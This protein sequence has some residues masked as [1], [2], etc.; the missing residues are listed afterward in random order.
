MATQEEL[1]GLRAELL[2]TLAPPTAV[3]EAILTAGVDI[4]EE[5]DTITLGVGGVLTE[6]DAAIAE[7]ASVELVWTPDTP[8]STVKD[9]F[10]AAGHVVSEDSPIV[11][12][13]QSGGS[14]PE[15]DFSAQVSS[16]FNSNN[17]E[18]LK[19]CQSVTFE[20]DGQTHAISGGFYG[21]LDGLG[22]LTL[23]GLTVNRRSD[24]PAAV[25]VESVVADVPVT[26]D[27]CVFTAD[28]GSNYK[29]G[30]HIKR[31][32]VLAADCDFDGFIEHGI[33]AHSPLGV[34]VAECGFSDCGRTG[35]QVSRRG[36]NTH[37]TGNSTPIYVFQCTFDNI[38]PEGYAISIWGAS[39]NGHVSILNN[40]IV[41]C[42]AGGVLISDEPGWNSVSPQD[43]LQWALGQGYDVSLDGSTSLLSG[44]DAGT[45][46]SE[47]KQP[48]PGAPWE[49]MP[50][51]HTRWDNFPTSTAS[52]IGNTVVLD[53][54]STRKEY[55]LEGARAVVT[56]QHAS[57]E[58]FSSQW[59]SDH[60]FLTDAPT[61]QA[62][63]TE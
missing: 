6:L 51:V 39:P 1:S 21:E 58:Y 7:L 42:L 36:Y 56:D 33:Y 29:W 37:V 13:M 22:S 18:W 54:A 30:A 41:D 11:V 25:M 50:P 48:N 45:A 15:V 26:L 10:V 5:I 40:T 17:G 49:P 9:A 2:S 52:V 55:S 63:P 62:P 14:Y 53:P 32:T 46:N 43:K 44:P 47:F 19:G 20:A 12:K 8:F 35:I 28:G 27:A 61:V 23:K 16:P 59:A 38:G 34:G 31:S 57:P 60:T 4:S 24:L 3:L